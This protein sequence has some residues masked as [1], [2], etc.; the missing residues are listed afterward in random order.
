MAMPDSYYADLCRSYQE[1]RDFIVPV[2]REAG[3]RPYTPHGAYYVMCDISDF[4]FPT[5]TAF[6][7]FLVE[8]LGVAVV[9]GSSF[10]SDPARGVHQVRFAFPKRMET[11]RA[12]GPRLQRLCELQS[13]SVP[14]VGFV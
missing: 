14:D 2:L 13:A 11:L 7:R 12:V 10:Y 4:R 5:D 3:F 8:D 9:P 1:R 6:A